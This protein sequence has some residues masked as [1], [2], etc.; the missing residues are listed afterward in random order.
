MQLFAT[1]QLSVVIKVDPYIAAQREAG[2]HADQCGVA[3][4]RRAFHRVRRATAGKAQML[5]GID[6]AEAVLP[7]EMATHVE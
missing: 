3:H 2:L 1:G 5:L 6:V 7:A 4:Q